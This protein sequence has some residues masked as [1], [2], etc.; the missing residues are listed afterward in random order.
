MYLPTKDTLKKKK[1]QLIWRGLCVFFP[2]IFFIKKATTKKKKK[3]KQNK[4][5]Q[6]K[7]KNNNK[8]TCCGYSF[9]LHR[10]V[11]AIQMSIHNMFF[12]LPTRYAFIKK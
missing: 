6:N 12:W 3:K 11:D 4:K 7:K 10:Q 9:E 2:L 5:K 1:N 8:K